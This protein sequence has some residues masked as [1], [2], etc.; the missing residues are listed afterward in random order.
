MSASVLIADDDPNILRALS[1]LMQREGHRVRTAVDGEQALAAI[2]EMPPDLVLLDLM[3]PKGD[4]YDVCRTLRVDRSY[5][6]PHRHADGEGD[7]PTSVGMDWRRPYQAFAIGD[8]VRCVTEVLAG[9][10]RGRRAGCRVRRHATAVIAGSGGD[11]AQ[12]GEAGP[13]LGRRRMQLNP[14]ILGLWAA[15]SSWPAP[16]YLFVVW[17]LSRRRRPDQRTRRVRLTT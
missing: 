11:A 10:S 5:E 13:M 14:P 12:D 9:G 17:A 4:G 7:G 6:C 3:M 8:A 16:F 15:R 1:F 2:A